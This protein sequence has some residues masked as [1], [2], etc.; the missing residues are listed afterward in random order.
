MFS[1][2]LYSSLFPRWVICWYECKNKHKN[3]CWETNKVGKQNG[4][5]DVEEDSLKYYILYMASVNHLLSAVAVR[6]FS[7]S[8][9]K[10][11][12][13]PNRC[14]SETGP[15]DKWFRNFNKRQSLTNRKPDQVD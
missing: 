7:W 5:S 9:A 15:R 3:K 2:A 8:I 10:K 11:N 6:G 14:N 1:F 13:C 12:D 4:L